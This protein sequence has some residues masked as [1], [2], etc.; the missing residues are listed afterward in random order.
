LEIAGRG[1]W[2]HTKLYVAHG[3]SVSEELELGLET[4][5]GYLGS[6]D[7]VKFWDWNPNEDIVDLRT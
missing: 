1:T 5:Q 2:K 3:S 6:E 4:Q 7:I